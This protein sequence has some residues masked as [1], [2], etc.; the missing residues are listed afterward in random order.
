[1]ERSRL[2]DRLLQAASRFGFDSLLERVE[3]GEDWAIRV[4]GP[5]EKGVKGFVSY[6][7]GPEVHSSLA[8]L[9]A[10][11]AFSGTAGLRV[12]AESRVKDFT[13]FTQQFRAVRDRHI[14]P[15]AAGVSLRIAVLPEETSSDARPIIEI[16]LSEHTHGSDDH[17]SL[18]YVLSESGGQARRNGEVFEVPIPVTE[19]RWNQ[20]VL[21]VT[22]DVVRGFPEH[23]G[24]DNSARILA[25]GVEVRRGAR[26][27]VCFDAFE[28]E[29][30]TTGQDTFVRQAALLREQAERTASVVQ[31]QGVEISFYGSHLNE[32]TVETELLDYE[33]LVT[34]VDP[35]GVGFTRDEARVAE[36][37]NEAAVARA[38]DKQGLVSCNHVLGRSFA[39]SPKKRPRADSMAAI[40]GHRCW[41]AD[42]LEVGYRDRG[43]FQLE[44]HLWLWD[45]LA[46]RQIFMVGTG[47]SDS[48]GST[49]GTWKDDPNNFVT[50]IYARSATKADLIEGL[51]RGRAFFGDI[52]V[53][54]GTISVRTA[55]GASMGDIVTTA[56]LSDWLEIEIV[57]TQPGDQV[58]LVRSGEVLEARR[59]DAHRFAYERAVAISDRVTCFRVELYSSELLAKAF[60]NPI[61]Y[62]REVPPRPSRSTRARLGQG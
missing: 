54:D 12:E 58:R 20:L 41:G 60:S 18:R 10:S 26:G 8:G 49:T 16:G 5:K 34:G 22:R 57:G 29:Q 4:P 25:M 17:P 38:H 44:D 45:E 55:S 7:G 28:I 50:W 61:C 9:Q 32:F 37:V 36:A 48:H 23:Q 59:A 40:E 35:G 62:V 33:V 51:A 53:F 46:Q 21:P 2:E 30:E 13:P 27:S 43:G 31:L 15:L 56:A 3:E 24:Q 47:V 11:C 52:T 42:L 14:R 39:G 19:G 6:R 1:M